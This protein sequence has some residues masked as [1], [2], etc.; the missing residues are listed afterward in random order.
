MF[1][2]GMRWTTILNRGFVSF[3]LLPSVSSHYVQDR[4]IWVDR[5]SLKRITYPVLVIPI[6]T[7]CTSFVVSLVYKALRMY[8]FA[9]SAGRYL[10]KA[11][12]SSSS[13]SELLRWVLIRRQF[14]SLCGVLGAGGL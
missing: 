1:S 11:S 4:A 6:P 12:V 9:E 7:T 13:E 5:S 2:V 3:I 14:R 10:L 8:V